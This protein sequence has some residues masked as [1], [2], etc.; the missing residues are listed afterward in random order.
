ML[1]LPVS[2]RARRRKTWRRGAKQAWGLSIFLKLYWHN[3]HEF[4]IILSITVC[5]GKRTFQWHHIINYLYLNLFL[6]FLGFRVYCTMEIVRLFQICIA[7]IFFAFSDKPTLR[8]LYSSRDWLSCQ[9]RP[10]MMIT[11]T[12]N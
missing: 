4:S 10:C 5:D 12:K 1:Y 6:M 11:D 9:S 2:R 3:L 8:A 7:Y